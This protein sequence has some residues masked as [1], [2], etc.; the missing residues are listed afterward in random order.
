MPPSVFT[1]HVIFSQRSSPLKCLCVSCFFMECILFIKL[2]LRNQNYSRHL[3]LGSHHWTL[4]HIVRDGITPRFSNRGFM[5]CS[6]LKSRSPV[7][8]RLLY[9]VR[10][11]CARDSRRPKCSAPRCHV[12]H[13][14]AF[15]HRRGH[16]IL[17]MSKRCMLWISRQYRLFPS[18]LKTFQG[19]IIRN[20]RRLKRPA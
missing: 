19:E 14:W 17:F 1:W 6:C 7:V 12:D 11:A 3:S 16:F 18:P 10:S 5:L 2:F 15:R 9:G 13:C 20:L 8:R 4:F